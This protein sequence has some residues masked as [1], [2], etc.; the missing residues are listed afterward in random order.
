MRTRAGFTATIAVLSLFAGVAG[1]SY[2][3]GHPLDPA[4]VPRLAMLAAFGVLL[5]WQRY[6]AVVQLGGLVAIQAGV[7]LTLM[8]GTPEPVAMPG[9]HHHESMPTATTEA[10]SDLPMMTAHL[11]GVLLAVALLHRAG[12]WWRRLLAVLARV[13]PVLPAAVSPLPVPTSRPGVAAAA[14]PCPERW[15]PAGVLRRGPPRV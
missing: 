9:H 15:L 4:A 7:H 14:V 5:G 8:G 1:H 10:G 12:V 2:V 6:G 11:A 3:D 13:L